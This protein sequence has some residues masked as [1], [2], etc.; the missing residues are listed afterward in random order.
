MKA[1]ATAQPKAETIQRVYNAPAN[2]EGW[3]EVVSRKDLEEVVE[4]N[5][6]L[7]SKYNELVGRYLKLSESFDTVAEGASNARTANSAT[8]RRASFAVTASSLQ[9]HASYSVG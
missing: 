9:Q 5:R 1:E 2:E 6:A 7:V 3:D 4:K 8:K